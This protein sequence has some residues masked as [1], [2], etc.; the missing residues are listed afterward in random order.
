MGWKNGIN[1]NF[2]KFL[3]RLC[4]AALDFILKKSNFPKYCCTLT[5]NLNRVSEYIVRTGFLKLSNAD[6]SDQMVLC[7]GCA[8]HVGPLAPSLASTP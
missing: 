3:V 4:R 1:V 8:V 2:S 7:G 5:D 6:I